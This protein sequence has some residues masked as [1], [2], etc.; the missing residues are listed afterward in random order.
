MFVFGLMCT[1]VAYTAQVD[2]ADP[3]QSQQVDEQ[4]EEGDV[5]EQ[6]SGSYEGDEED[7]EGQL[8]DRRW[9]LGIVYRTLQ[10]GVEVRRVIRNSPAHRAGLERGDVIL[11]ID[12]FIIDRNNP[13]DDVL[14][15]AGNASGN[16]RVVLLVRDIRTGNLVRLRVQLIRR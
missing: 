14:Q 5:E 2:A 6:S 9:Y 12:H 13:F 11:R 10:R 1:L 4:T 8:R 3:K 15:R 7:V 16:G